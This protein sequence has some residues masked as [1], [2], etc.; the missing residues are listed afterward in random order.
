MQHAHTLYV[1][2]DNEKPNKYSSFL[3]KMKYSWW[4][5]LDA[6]DRIC[7]YWSIRS[8]FV[9]GS[10]I[11]IQVQHSWSI[12]T[13]FYLHSQADTG[14]GNLK[15]GDRRQGGL[16]G[17][18]DRNRPSTPAQMTVNK[19]YEGTSSLKDSTR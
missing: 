15:V 6:G 13:S 10:V 1:L 12:E 19:K 16:L 8:C 3:L 5:F 17:N 9:S 18:D 4:N 7:E 2:A 11:R 14:S